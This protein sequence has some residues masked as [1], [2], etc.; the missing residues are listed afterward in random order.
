MYNTL[1]IGSFG[2]YL[3]AAYKSEDVI[4]DPFARQTLWTGE[5]NEGKFV[6]EPGYVVY[7]SMSGAIG[8][9][10]G[11][12]EYKRTENFNFRADPFLDL[13]AGMLNFLPPMMR[14][15]HL[16]ADSAL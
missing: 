6:L 12:I 7:T 10:S 11:D 13:N 2:W 1:S 4:F 14:L 9:F 5:T 15:K 8:K 16:P 3:E